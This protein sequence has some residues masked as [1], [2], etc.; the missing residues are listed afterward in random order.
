MSLLP[1]ADSISHFLPS[2][3][4]IVTLRIVLIE[5]L[6]VKINLIIKIAKVLLL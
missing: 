6:T 5:V 3:R 2:L 1:L 4:L